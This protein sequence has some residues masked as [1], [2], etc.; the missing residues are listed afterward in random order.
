MEDFAFEE[1]YPQFDSYD[2]NKLPCVE[3]LRDLGI[4][5]RKYLG[6]KGPKLVMPC[7]YFDTQKIK[8]QAVE[9]FKKLMKTLPEIPDEVAKSEE[10]QSIGKAKEIKPI[11]YTNFGDDAGEDELEEVLLEEPPSPRRQKIKSTN[12]FF[13][14]S[15]SEVLEITKS[16]VEEHKETSGNNDNKP[17]QVEPP[18]MFDLLRNLEEENKAQENISPNEAH[19]LDDSFNSDD[20][21]EAL[22]AKD[23][24]TQT[25]ADTELKTLDNMNEEEFRH[26][27]ESVLLPNL[28]LETSLALSSS[29]KDELVSDKKP[30]S[31]FDLMKEIQ[32]LKSHPKQDEESKEE[33]T[34]KVNTELNNNFQDIV[35]VKI[36]E[37]E[38]PTYVSDE[39]EEKEQEEPA[40][41]TEVMKFEF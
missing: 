13:S 30:E 27:I 34:F 40:E 38:I 39:E 36:R 18:S 41:Y 20:V 12:G 14:E 3:I 28:N 11:K 35:A 5:P 31:K 7:D 21:L 19:S 9:D 15:S 2:P 29:P 10:Y 8:E 6:G 26:E 33:N 37:A 24:E 25:A 23:D 1:K 17:E 4:D 22:D 16:L 32:S